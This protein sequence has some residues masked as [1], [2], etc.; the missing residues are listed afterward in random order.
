VLSAGHARALL[1]LT[2]AADIER[3]AAR[4]VAEGLSVR[5][6]EEIISVGAAGDTKAG[7][8]KGKRP[9]KG[10]TISTPGL[11]DLGSRMSERLDTRVKVELGRTRGKISIE[12]ATLEDLQRIV[13]I[14]APTE[15]G[16]FGEP[17]K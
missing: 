5:S 9:A 8:T 13:D 2:D 10:G 17:L 15:R 16:M 7:A 12:F 4:I 3:L 6:V 11:N 14:V 1:A